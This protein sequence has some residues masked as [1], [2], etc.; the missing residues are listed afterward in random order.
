MGIGLA[1]V[2][3]FY[4]SLSMFIGGFIALILEKKKKAI[5]EKYIVP[6]SSG[7]IAGES[8]MG[9]GIALYDARAMFTAFLEPIRAMLRK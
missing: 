3:P 5:A 7:I 1:M 2:I 9:V 4:N 8:L 6:I